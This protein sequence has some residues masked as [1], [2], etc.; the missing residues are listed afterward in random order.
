MLTE[1]CGHHCGLR[2]NAEGTVASEGHCNCD[3]CH[4]GTWEGPQRVIL[5][6]R[7]RQ[8]DARLP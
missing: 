7:K 4:D 8:A 6:L 3:E 5:D 1:A 2:P